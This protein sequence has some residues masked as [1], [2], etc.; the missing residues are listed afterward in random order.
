MTI[1]RVLL[2]RHGQTEWNAA[3]RWQ[4]HEQTPLNTEGQAQ[5]KALAVYLRDRPIRALY[6]SDLLRAW[7]TAGALAEALRLTPQADADWREHH[8]GIFQGMTREQIEVR[9]PAEWTLMHS[10]YWEYVFPNGESRGDLRQRACRA[11]ETVLARAGGPEVAVVSHGGTIKMLL[12]RLFGETPEIMN[13]HI[14][15]TSITTLERHTNDWRLVE[16]GSAPHLASANGR[17]IEGR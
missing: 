5:T 3:G 6:S 12:L 8:L 7:Q 4:G 11:W 16:I 13:F 1:Q 9:Y 14:P 17:E 15:N 10:D 2:I